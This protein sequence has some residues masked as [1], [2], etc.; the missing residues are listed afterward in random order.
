VISGQVHA[1]PQ[2]EQVIAL[3]EG[4]QITVCERGAEGG[5]PVLALHGTPGSRIKFDVADEPARLLGL[6]LISPDR[7]GYGGTSPHPRPSLR[8]WAEDMAVLADSLGI[9]RFSVL[10]VSGGG[11][12]AAAVAACLPT[13][14]EALAL[15]APVGPIANE[16]GL[17]MR[18]F[19]R[20]CFGPFA[21]SPVAVATVFAGLRRLLALSR[22]LGM[23]IAMSNVAGA[24]RTVLAS[25]GVD[26]RLART[27]ALGL[28][29]GTRGPVT[30]LHI[31][32]TPWNVDLGAARVAARLWIGTED[33]NVPFDAA[34]RLCRKLPTC[35][36]ETIPGAGH[37][38]VAL[39][40]PHVLG[41]IAN[42]KGAASAAP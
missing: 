42:T 29:P 18:A 9:D 34:R 16:E 36:L 13:R 17:E 6:R 7:W 19:H 31:F 8:A 38:W 39:N 1:V 41:W 24:D 4:R 21:R 28:A 12:Y 11:P 40:Y 37:L 2:R 22:P 23:R 35:E 27:F 25:G 32:S 3:P 33:Q 5:F 30:D 20:F 14:V 26:Q 10:A 15:V